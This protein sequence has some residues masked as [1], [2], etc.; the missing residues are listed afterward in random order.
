[1]KAVRLHRQGGPEQL[2]YEDAPRPELGAG[3][4]LVRVH[5]TGITPA[6][7]T[8]AETYR[9][10]DGSERLPA[11]P[12]HEV[13]GVVESVADG[14]D[15]VMI[16]EEV[17]ALTSFCRDG[18]AAEYVGVR[19]ADL[20]PKPKSLN[21]TQAAAVPLSA[22]TVW[23]AFFDHAHL[24][25]G[26]RVLIHG[27]AGGVGAFAVQIAR[28]LGAYVIGTASAENRDFLL[29]LGADEAIDYRQTQFEQVLHD[30]D[31]VLDTIGGETR[32]RSWQVLKPTG[33]LVTL[34][35]P[36]PESE[37][38]EHGKRG[39]RGLFFVVKPDREQLGK[40]AEL[41][42]SGVIRPVIAETIPLAKARQAFER[43]VAG[44]TRG[45]LVLQVATSATQSA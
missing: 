24:V 20:A 13:S 19:A 34:P 23:Q 39:R 25:S 11:I 33:I 30:V 29:R 12:G 9:N 44:H 45:K 10:C 2:V 28:W 35:G 32:E 31:V 21:H 42:D 16:G 15:D 4:A 41:I 14:V 1:M 26:Q 40:I 37:A 18:A 36:I 8:W 22:L 38:I 3:D 7:L 17:Y 27:A 43:G 5:A 6:E